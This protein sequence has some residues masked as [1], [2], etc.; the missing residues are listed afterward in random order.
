MIERWW[1]SIKKVIRLNRSINMAKQKRSIK[2]KSIITIGIEHEDD[3]SV[4]LDDEIY[5]YYFLIK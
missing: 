5:H 1:D 2:G 3:E 4:I